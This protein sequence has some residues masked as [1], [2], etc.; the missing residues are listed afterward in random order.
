[1]EVEDGGDHDRTIR[2]LGTGE[3][4]PGSPFRRMITAADTG[5]RFSTLSVV[6]GPGDLVLPHSHRDEDEFS[7]VFRGRIGGRIGDHDVTVEEGGFL[8]K[9]T[10]H[11]AHNMELDGYRGDSP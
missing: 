5:G 6:L 11:R 9:P 2:R 10:R 1:M 8:F 4:I 3:A 7:F